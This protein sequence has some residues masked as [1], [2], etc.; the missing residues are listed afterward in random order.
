MMSRAK[1]L[2]RRHPPPLA[3][4]GAVA[5]SKTKSILGVVC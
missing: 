3:M 1:T 4:L 5:S 2:G